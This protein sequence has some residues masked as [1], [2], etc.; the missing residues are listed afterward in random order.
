MAYAYIEE[1]ADGVKTHWSLPFSYLDRAFVKVAVVHEDGTLESPDFSFVDASTILLSPAIKAGRKVRRYRATKI[2]APMVD[3]TTAAVL[4]EQDLDTVA[5]QG[6]DLAQ[7]VMD[8]LEVAERDVAAVRQIGAATQALVDAAAKAAQDAA[9]IAQTVVN[10]ANLALSQAVASHG[11]VVAVKQEV[12]DFRTD[13]QTA[14]TAVTA[15]AADI[16]AMKT[17]VAQA[18]A[19]VAAAVSTANAAS[20][21]ANAIS[22]KATQA[23]A[24]AAQAKADAAAVS[25]DHANMTASIAANTALAT[26]AKDKSDSAYN[27]ANQAQTTVQAVAATA[28]Q[29]VADAKVAKTAA[30]AAQTTADTAKATADAV[31]TAVAG[32]PIVQVRRDASAGRLPVSTVHTRVSGTTIVDSHGAV[33]SYSQFTAPEDGW[34]SFSGRI[35]F[36]TPGAGT[37]FMEF[38]INSQVAVV[39]SLRVYVAADHLLSGQEMF[40]MRKG[41]VADIVADFDGPSGAFVHAGASSDPSSATRW[42]IIKER[43]L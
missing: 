4:T 18:K 29:G 38:N 21:A 28:A 35:L 5:T 10:T 12:T 37:V 41:D 24:D 1:V 7:E 34:Y 17:E 30:D 2:D 6:V 25:A 20:T 16:A 22:D 14:T 19:D 43:D 11:E 33:N 31:K 9:A 40:R 15:A 3:F 36:N 8:A 26:S 13:V 32:K 23:A 27:I 39:S 42:T